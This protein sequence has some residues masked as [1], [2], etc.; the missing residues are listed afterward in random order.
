[1]T[2]NSKI[3]SSRE[4]AR[5]LLRELFQF[6]AQDLDFGI[7]RI[8]NFRRKEIERFID[9]DLIEAV[10]AEFREYAKASM[11]ELQK[12]VERLKTEIN[13][14]FG[15]GTVDEQGHVRKHEG[16]PKVQ[17]YVKKVEE[18]KSGDVS[19][20]QM[21]E[22]FNHV[23][24]FFS[25]YYDK[26]DF[27]SKRRYGG[28]EKYYVPYNGEEVVLHWASK[29]QYYVKTS[30]YFRSY[31]FRAG[32]FQVNFLLKEA[33]VEVNNVVGENEYFVLCDPDA[34]KIDDEKKTVDICFEW[35]A[36]A[37]DEKRKFGTRNVQ[38]QLVAEA[39]DKIFSET[40]GSRAGNELRVKV[41]E[42][43]TVLEKHLNDYVRRN[44]TDYFVHKDLRGFLEREL[45]FYIK[46][47][48]VDLDEL[49]NSDEKGVRI[50]RAKA[51][52]IRGISRKIIEFLAQIENFQKMLFEKK[53]LVIRTE[54]SITIDRVPEELWDEVLESKAQIEE[55]KELYV[56][57]EP[58]AKA[59]SGIGNAFLR[60]YP[61]L[62]IDTCHFSDDFKWKL[63]ASFDDLDNAWDGLLI[64][65][66]SFQA[67]SLLQTRWNTSVDCVYID[68]PFN[69]AASTI[70]YKNDYKH[71]SWL[72]LMK[73][74]IQSTINL[75][76]NDSIIC[77]AIDDYELPALTYCL[78]A[79]FGEERHL[80]TVVVRSNPHGRAM[81]SGF[82]TNH[83]YALFFGK[84]EQAVIG[85]LP[86]DEKGLTRYPKSDESGF[87]AWI[88]FR[89]T[90][91]HTR[92]VDRPRLFYH[93]Y[94]S[95]TGEIRVPSMSWSENTRQWEPLEA[96]KPHE[97][98]VV[99]IDDENRE[100]VWTLG[101]ERARGEVQS[102][103]IIAK[104]VNGKWQ[105]HR[106]YR[107]HQE[108]AIPGTWWD[109]ARYSATESGT[110]VLKDMFGERERFPYPKSVYLVEDCLRASNCSSESLV[111]DFLAGSGTT[112]HA[113]INLNQD[114][115]KRKYI[116]VEMA[117]YFD[118]V[119]L[120]RIKKAAFSLKWKDGK[121][122]GRKGVGHMV[123]YHYLEQYEDTLNNI[124]FVEKDKTI[125]E[126]LDEFGDYLLKNMLDFETRNSRTRLNVELFGQPFDYKIAVTT[127]GGKERKTA[128]VDLVE[129]FNYLLG[130]HVRKFRTFRD[131]QR[132]YRCVFGKQDAENVAVIWR[133]T[134]DIDL[135]RDKRFIEEKILTDV[136]PDR[137]FINAD[138]IVEKAE[139]IEPE[140]KRLMGA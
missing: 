82:S 20:A 54:Y 105:I 118:T 100:R 92:R 28:R 130:L 61:T 69:T 123:K 46:N 38:E 36:L 88:N 72:S 51:R 106:K 34:V 11:G 3:E 87:F 84:T 132:E 60:E 129:T 94:V 58:F 41:D 76:K 110:K 140:F 1:M 35:R 83:E 89:G 71:S 19:E 55:W 85:R 15:E 78:S 138:S 67:L 136:K 133:N 57:E 18:L 81:A 16:A 30:E 29:D 10:E 33:E 104:L 134:T 86:R 131:Q 56:L 17:D 91:A 59:K 43:R 32:A 137:I 2:V 115:G 6:D 112:A 4:K 25:R 27:I 40:S 113:I 116:L 62:M 120:P 111:L 8:L 70:L 9:E 117:D 66:E 24:E 99:P 12:E 96:L 103:N 45:E 65:S 42:E 47:E 23:Y 90:G 39:V 22:V 21:N 95:K 128:T 26:G 74:R 75:M 68:P 135:V 97:S 102:G 139:P 13:R 5:H 50:A 121:P 52:A 98:I 53:K 44:T 37:D 79:I 73:D 127:N 31:S 80:A 14:D 48:A 124:A 63:L 108:G 126:T 77:L 64:K 109:D 107:P 49:E 114:G 101:W 125:Q 119:L 93:V 7:Y 122:V